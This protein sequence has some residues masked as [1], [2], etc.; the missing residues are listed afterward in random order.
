M[1]DF[2][3]TVC[4]GTNVALLCANFTR[5]DYL[6]V[7]HVTQCQ[8]STVSCLGVGKMLEATLRSATPD[9]LPVAAL[10]R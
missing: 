3:M 4:T 2:Y 10:D 7:L 1:T 8:A 5:L 9:V 6:L